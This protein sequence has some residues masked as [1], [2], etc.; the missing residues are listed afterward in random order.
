MCM[1]MCMHMLNKRV[2]ILFN[3]DS[4]NKLIKSAKA[5]N[6]SAGEFIRRAVTEELNKKKDV[7]AEKR[8][9]FK[10]LFKPKPK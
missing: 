10:G 4:W 1:L 8:S 9:P 6:I 2:H 3:K 7:Q 5:Q